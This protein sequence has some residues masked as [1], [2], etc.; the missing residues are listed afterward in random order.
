MRSS[1][2][3]LLSFLLTLAVLPAFA[4]VTYAPLT[5]ET[6]RNNGVY[7]ARPVSLDTSGFARTTGRVSTMGGSA[8]F[9]VSVR[10]ARPAASLILRGAARLMP[11]LAVAA[12]A[13]DIYSWIKGYGIQECPSNTSAWCV[14]E[15]S[16]TP[17]QQPGIVCNSSN[18]PWINCAWPSPDGNC[19]AP[20]YGAIGKTYVGFSGSPWGFVSP[21]GYACTQIY[22]DGWRSAT[23][24]DWDRVVMAPMPAI[25]SGWDKLAASSD[26]PIDAWT[27][28]STPTSA[29]AGSPYFGADGKYRRDALI[30]NPANSIFPAQVRVESRT[31]GPVADPDQLTTPNPLPDTPQDPNQPSVDL[32][33]LNPTIIACA[34]QEDYYSR[35]QSGTSG[36]VSS[37]AM[38]QQEFEESDKAFGDAV[39]AVGA[40]APPDNSISGAESANDSLDNIV[41]N[42]DSVDLP[43]LANI[44]TP[45]YSQCKTITFEYQ[46]STFVFPTSSQCEKI[47]QIKLAFGYFLAGLVLVSLVW[48]LLT[49][50]QG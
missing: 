10:A 42:I 35:M 1:W 47:E 12:A 43:G 40:G 28:S 2:L 7:T 27:T 24:A 44:D 36:A 41:S 16:P 11:A 14:H 20:N 5:I 9:G 6:V 48:Q 45:S 23:D 4:S 46:N 8:S 38:T 22:K 49:R 31:F 32:C 3:F 21:S 13:Y 29:W 33:A 25:S 37:A 17:V 50:P 15:G 26:L 18:V 34:Q 39:D 19:P 30:I